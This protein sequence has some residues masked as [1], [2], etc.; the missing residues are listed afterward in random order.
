[1]VL[2]LEQWQLNSWPKVALKLPG[3]GS[4]KDL[5][6]LAKQCEELGLNYSLLDYDL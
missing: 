1:V 2:E 5:E 4:A 3:N 6:Q